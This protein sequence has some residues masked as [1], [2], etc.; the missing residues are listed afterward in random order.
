MSLISFYVIGMFCESSLFQTLPVHSS[1]GKLAYREI[2]RTAS[3]YDPQGS[4]SEQFVIRSRHTL[5]SRQIEI[6]I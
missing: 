2:L 3:D 1:A 4:F 5:N 6:S